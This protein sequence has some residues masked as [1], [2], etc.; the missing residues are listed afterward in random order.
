MKSGTNS[1]TNTDINNDYSSS[2]NYYYISKDNTNSSNNKNGNNSDW[3]QMRRFEL[4][5]KAC[6]PQALLFF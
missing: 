1:N 4:D 2:N 5:L 6:Q 3:S